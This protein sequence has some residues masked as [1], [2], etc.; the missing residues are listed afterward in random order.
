MKNNN[1]TKYVAAGGGIH[2]KYQIRERDQ[3]KK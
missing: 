3:R 1:L 2:A